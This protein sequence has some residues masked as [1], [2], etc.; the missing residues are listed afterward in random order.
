MRVYH[1]FCLI[2]NAHLRLSKVSFFFRD[3][4]TST[5]KRTTSYNSVAKI[6]VARTRIY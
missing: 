6:A 4:S 5:L 1:C 3:A 2:K